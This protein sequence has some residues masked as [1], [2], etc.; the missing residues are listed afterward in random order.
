MKIRVG[1]E[2]EEW[3]RGDRLMLYQVL[4]NFGTKLMI[5]DERVLQIARE[6]DLKK[7]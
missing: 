4:A 2:R 5:V 7:T 3:L 1:E 6:E